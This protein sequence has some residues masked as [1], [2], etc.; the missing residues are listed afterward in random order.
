MLYVLYASAQA[1]TDAIT[2]GPPHPRGKLQ[3]AGPTQDSHEQ[4]PRHFIHCKDIFVIRQYGLR[5]V[6]V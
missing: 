1:S 2:T 5:G 6:V 4:Q 3:P